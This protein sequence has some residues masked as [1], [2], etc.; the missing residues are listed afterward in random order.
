[1]SCDQILYVEVANEVIRHLKH[2]QSSSLVIF[3][4]IRLFLAF[5]FFILECST[6]FISEISSASPFLFF[7]ISSIF[8]AAPFL[9]PKN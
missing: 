8:S 3:S 4:K 6:L 5:N 9:F 7:Q 1:M 2:D